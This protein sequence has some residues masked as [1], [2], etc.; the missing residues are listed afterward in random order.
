MCGVFMSLANS[1]LRPPVFADNDTT[2]AAAILHFILITTLIISVAALLAIVLF[3][4]DSSLLLILTALGVQAVML[5]LLYRGAVWLAGILLCCVAW[6]VVAVAVHNNLGALN[7]LLGA[8]TLVILLAGLLINTRAALV[9]MICSI[10]YTTWLVSAA[11]A[12][13]FIAEIGTMTVQKAWINEVGLFALTG[14]LLVVSLR[15]IAEARDRASETGRALRKS[16]ERYRSL[17]QNGPNLIYV[18]EPDHAINFVSYGMNGTA[19]NVVGRQ[20]DDFINSDS[21]IAFRRTLNQVF[22]TRDADRLEIQGRSASGQTGWFLCHFAPIVEDEKVIEVAVI[23]TDISIRKRM[24]LEQRAATEQYRKLFE[25]NPLPMFVVDWESLKILEVNDAMMA[26]YGYTHDEFLQMHIADISLPETE[27][28]IQERVEKYRADNT[29]YDNG[30]VWQQHKKDGSVVWV[31]SAFHRLKFGGREAGLMVNFDLTDRMNAEKATLEAEKLRL[32][33][34]KQKEVLAL[35]EN[36]IAMMSHEFRTPLAVILSSKE[37]L[38]HYFDRISPERRI[39]KLRQ[40]GV[41][42]RYVIRLLDDVLMMGQAYA[43]KLQFNPVPM[44]LE[45]VC[46]KLFEEMKVTDREEHT[47]IF[48]VQNEIGTI[49]SDQHLL[50][51]IIVNLVSNAIKYTP[52]GREICMNIGLEGDQAYIRVSDQGV[53]IPK[54]DQKHLFEPFFRA[55]NVKA[56]QGTGLGLSIV[57]ESVDI[58]GGSISCKSETGQGTTFTVLLPVKAVSVKPN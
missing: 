45:E 11:Q 34:A 58:H 14:S 23:M 44:N 41:Q 32:D 24:E 37:T 30:I 50:Q 36:F 19:E 10:I 12:G 40:I 5:V 9:A 57:K 54:E 39:E 56:Y 46:Q 22:R 20:I 3:A 8:H 33:L 42:V 6:L 4:S 31:E 28:A 27:A 7:P 49:D 29:H 18:V 16:E 26:R 43:G 2:R 48:E 15:A 21:E 1:I 55:D 51:H 47:F 35:K 52:T 17:V 53:G 38:E 25:N 13:Q